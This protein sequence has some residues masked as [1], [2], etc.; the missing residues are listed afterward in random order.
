MK[1]YFFEGKFATYFFISQI[2]PMFFKTFFHKRSP[3]WIFAFETRLFCVSW[4][5]SKGLFAFVVFFQNV[6]GLFLFALFGDETFAVPSVLYL[7]ELA[8][9]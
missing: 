3:C 7:V 4:W 9:R 6:E 1:K 5:T 2:L 8:Q